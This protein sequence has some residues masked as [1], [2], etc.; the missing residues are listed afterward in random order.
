MNH[1]RLFLNLLCC[2][3]LVSPVSVLARVASYSSRLWQTEDGLPH[4]TVHTVAQTLDGYLWIGTRGGLVRF[5]GVRFTSFDAAT[6]PGLANSPILTL[7]VSRDGTLWIGTE[8]AGLSSFK[9]GRFTHWDD[10]ALPHPNIRS[11]REGADGSLWIASYGSGLTRYQAGQFTRLTHDNGLADDTVRNVFEDRQGNLW[12]ATIWGLSHVNKGVVTNYSEQNGLQHNSVRAVCEDNEGT[13]WIGSNG[14]LSR[15]RD[16]R[17]THFTKK[18]GLSDNVVSALY[19]DRKGVL[20]IGTYEGLNRYED[21]KFLVETRGSG[22]SYNQIYS[23]FEDRE[24]NLWVGTREGLNRL[25]ACPFQSYTRRDGLTHNTITS[26][27]ED[28]FGTLWIGTGGGLNFFK[29]GIIGAYTTA[30][31]LRSDLVRGLHE[32][33]EG[34]LWFGTSYDGGLNRLR[35]GQFTFYGR[36]EL[37]DSPENVIHE[38]RDGNVWLG[39]PF[40]LNRLKNGRFTRYSTETAQSLPNAEVVSMCEDHEGVIWIGTGDGLTRWKKEQLSMEGLDDLPKRRVLALHEDSGHTMWI[41]LERHGL[42]RFQAGKFTHYTLKEGLFDDVIFAMLEDDQGFF[43]MASPKGIF[44]FRKKDLDDLDRGLLKTISC[45]AF[46]KDDGMASAECQNVAKPAACRSRDGRL[47]FSTIKGL[48]VV[49]P[50]AIAINTIAPPMTIEEII[51]DKNTVGEK[52]NDR[53]TANTSLTLPPG[54]GE[55][56][57]HYTALS[58]SAPEKNRFKYKLEGVDADWVK[59]GSRRVAYYNNIPPGSYT[60]RVQG[61]NS[62]DVWNSDGANITLRL[63]PHFWQTW[64]FLGSCS[65]AALVAVAGTARYVTRRKLQRQLELLEQQHAVEKERSRIARDMHDN[66]G[67]SLTEILVL[68]TL[69]RN[70][71]DNPAQVESQTDRIATVAGRVNDS[72]HGIVWAINPKNDSLDRLASYLF[73]HAQGFL[74]TASIRCR[75]DVPAVL[76]K[77]PLSSEVRHNVFLAAKEALNNVVKYAEA[78]EVVIR[79]RLEPSALCISITDNGRGFVVKESDASGNGLQNMKKRMETVGGRFEIESSP[80]NGTRIH[81]QIP[82]KSRSVSPT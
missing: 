46:G 32:S 34:S 16:G 23:I 35:D 55:L 26:V 33:R 22:E 64:W 39:S 59:A 78:S 50:T 63:L 27:C 45:L 41:A 43:W 25:K 13:L 14:G 70:A 11:L 38:D 28:Q 18:D 65:L 48:V 15:F 31:G 82:I 72:L 8:T 51:F 17:F 42:T 21:G 81:L 60:F 24:G 36:P 54:R 68:T 67:A 2:A 3:L 7:C 52:V 56:E 73:E 66:L 53:I 58:F 47:W 29:N 74:E 79:L 76:P 1:R 77:I 37:W 30:N 5:D 49:D 4:N 40:A 71:R 69:T 75:L 10:P 80:G 20:W 62:D 9:N 57:F 19:L 44:R 61:C 12:V 6:T